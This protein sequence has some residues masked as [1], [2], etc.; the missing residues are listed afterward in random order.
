VC[1]SLA[2][3]LYNLLGPSAIAELLVHRAGRLCEENIDECASSPCHNGGTCVDQV[4][5]FACRCPSGY[6][7][8]RCASVINECNSSPCANGATCL[9]G[10]NRSG[11]AVR[12]ISVIAKFHC[13]GPTGP[14]QTESVD[15]VGHRLHS[16]TRARPDPARTFLR[17]GSLRNSVGSVRVSDKVDAGPVGPA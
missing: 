8:N 15:F 6:Y 14:D 9:D 2:R 1:V 17:P 4:D 7:D 12:R 10:T 5:G 13:T 16:T 3:R 11:A